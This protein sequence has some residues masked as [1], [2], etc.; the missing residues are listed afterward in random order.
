MTTTWLCGKSAFCG[1]SKVSFIF[2]FWSIFCGVG[3]DT[4]CCVADQNK[5]VVS[6]TTESATIVK[7]PA[8]YIMEAGPRVGETA[9]IILRCGAEGWPT[10]TYQWYKVSETL[11]Q[12]FILF[13]IFVA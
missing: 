2:L 7:Q 5:I 11:A 4:F 13:Y 6:C 10:P 3:I 12:S 1:P 9:S 8:Q